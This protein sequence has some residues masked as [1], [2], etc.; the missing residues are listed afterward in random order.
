MVWRRH[1]GRLVEEL[2]PVKITPSFVRTADGSCLIELGGTR[3]ICTASFVAGAPKWRAEAGL[4]WVTAEYG[5]LP[6]STGSRKSRPFVNPDG[7]SVEIQRTIGRVLRN[8]VRFDRLGENTVYLDCDV[9]E[10]D[11]GTRTA[12]ITGAYVALALAIIKE[13]KA[14]RCRPDVLAGAVAAVSVGI[15][16]GR[17]ALDLDYAEDSAAEVDMNIAMTNGG[18]FVEVQGTGERAGFSQDQLKTMLALG[19]RGIRCLL[20]AQRKVL[21]RGS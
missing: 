3:V 12:A 7:R 4:G 10:A 16:D 14:G 2:R 20:A 5:M 15:I 19:R 21:R 11:G 18:K 17:A 13:A 1:D 8:I 6:A 9:L